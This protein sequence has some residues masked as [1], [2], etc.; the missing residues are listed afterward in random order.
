MER[1]VAPAG[2]REK[3]STFEDHRGK[4]TV[5][6]FDKL[7]FVPARAY[8]ISELSPGRRRGGHASRTQH[9]FLV[10]LSGCAKTTLDDGHQCEELELRPPEAV[11]VPPG[12]WLQLEG[13]AEESSILV[14]ADGPYD[15][16]DH[17]SDRSLLPI[18]SESASH[19]ADA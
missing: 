3:A 14:L 18:A 4:L 19:T 2:V 12:T 16:D 1:R 8:V 5:V 13:L 9:K 17:F 15:P 7:P 10:A 11:H 6:P